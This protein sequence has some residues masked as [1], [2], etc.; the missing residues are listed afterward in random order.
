MTERPVADDVLGRFA[1]QQH[2][3]FERVRKGSLDPEEVMRAVQAVIDRSFFYLS[4]SA[5]RAG[6]PAQRRA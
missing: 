6:S 2:D 4:K 5:A 1:R 3:L